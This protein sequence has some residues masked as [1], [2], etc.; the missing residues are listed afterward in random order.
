MLRRCVGGFWET[1]AHA[2]AILT[3][4][5]TPFPPDQLEA[6]AGRLRQGLGNDYL[7]IVIDVGLRW[8]AAYFRGAPDLK[9]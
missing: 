2:Q 6:T 9:R 4:R 5:E 3:L 1:L 8:L 7:S